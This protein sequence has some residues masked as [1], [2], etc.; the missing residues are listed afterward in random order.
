MVALGDRTDM[1]FQNTQ[2]TRGA[3][4]FVVTATG[5][6]TQIGQVAEMVTSTKRSRLPLQREL[7]GMTKVFGTVAV[8]V[9][10]LD[11]PRLDPHLGPAL[12]QRTDR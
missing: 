7:N 12:V 3:A 8:P 4:T 9:P 11:H 1:V 2:V 10:G 5:Q 6:A